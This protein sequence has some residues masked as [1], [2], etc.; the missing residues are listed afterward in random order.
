MAA[1]QPTTAYRSYFNRNRVLYV[2]HSDHDEGDLIARAFGEQ[3][4]MTST[5]SSFESLARL[6]RL[7][8][9]DVVLIDLDLLVSDGRDI[10]E[11]LRSMTFGVRIFALTDDHPNASHI[12]Q[13]VRSGTLSVFVRPYQVTDMIQAVTEELRGDL[14]NRLGVRD[15]TVVAGPGSLTQRELEVLRRIADGETNKEIGQVLG[16][17]PRTVEVHR[18]SAMRKLGAKNTAQLVR[19]ALAG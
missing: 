10:I 18:A 6:F 1:G 8:A 7:H 12:V 4:F 14:R 3:G 11:T 16:I 2:L 15:Q 19:I 9:P 13:A 5:S 17:S